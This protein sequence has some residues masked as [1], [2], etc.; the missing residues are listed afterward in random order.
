MKTTERVNPGRYIRAFSLIEVFIIAAAAIV[1]L[2]GCMAGQVLTTATMGET[3]TRLD[4]EEGA[5]VEPAP[6]APTEAGQTL[7]LCVVKDGGG[8]V[9]IRSGPGMAWPVVGY[10]HPGDTLTITG[11]PVNGWQPV[12]FHGEAGYFYTGSWC[13]IHEVD[14]E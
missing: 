7:T 8:A 2:T 3:V 9:H 14:Y 5:G 6:G 1:L 12:T 4:A 10:A 13:D 11:E